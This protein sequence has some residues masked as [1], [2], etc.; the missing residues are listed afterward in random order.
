VVGALAIGALGNLNAVGSLSGMA[1]ARVP[2]AAANSTGDASRVVLYKGHPA[3]VALGPGE[4]TLFL[5]NKGSPSANWAQNSGALRREMR[6]GVPIRD[7]SVNPVTGAL[8]NNTNFLKAERYLLQERGWVYD[9]KT[10][11]WMPPG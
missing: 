1:R 5:P 10:T 3:Q 4:R 2:R 11:L 8:E 7:A 6:R 9:P